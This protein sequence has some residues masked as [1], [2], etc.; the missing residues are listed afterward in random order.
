VLE[1]VFTY[2]VE[3]LLGVVS[4]ATIALLYL[5][6]T[7]ERNLRADPST[8]ASV[9]SLVADNQSLL[10]DLQNMDCCTTEEIE[11]RL[12]LRRYKLVNDE[13]ETGSVQLWSKKNVRKRDVC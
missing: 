6:L 12:R 13:F 11:E 3:G 4:L 9:M 1:P 7:R 2:I 10:S 8:I 5:S